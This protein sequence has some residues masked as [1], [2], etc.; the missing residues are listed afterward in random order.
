MKIQ[1][2]NIKSAASSLIFLFF[3]GCYS[4]TGGSVPDHLKTIVI[5]TVMDV[6]S[7]GVPE[8]KDYLTEELITQFRSDGSLKV[9]DT[10]GDSQLNVKISFITETISQVNPGELEKERKVQV[11]CRVEYYDNVLKKVVWEKDFSNYS[12]YSVS[13]GFTGRNEAIRLVLK[14]NAEDI[15]LA[16]ISGW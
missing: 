16:V 7:F 1:K 15:L 6:S 14:N 13:E 10:R 5:P 2:I 9:E 8:F 3:W 12:F 11:T 4:F